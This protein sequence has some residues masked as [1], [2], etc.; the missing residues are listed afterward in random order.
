MLATMSES[1]P[2]DQGMDEALHP[3]PVS[4]G[5]ELPWLL[6]GLTLLLLLWFVGLDEGAASVVGGGGMLH[7]LVHDGRHVLAFPCH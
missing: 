6:F 4:L 5:R 2:V 3:P 7:E 1:L